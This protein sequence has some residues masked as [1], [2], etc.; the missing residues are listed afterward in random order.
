MNLFVEWFKNSL[1]EN[2]SYQNAFSFFLTPK[3]VMCVI[4]LHM[5]YPY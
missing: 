3:G 2:L 5:C 1:C 4:C